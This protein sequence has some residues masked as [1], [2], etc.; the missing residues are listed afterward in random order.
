MKEIIFR[1]NLD[2]LDNHDEN[3]KVQAL[4]KLQYDRMKRCIKLGKEMEIQI[5]ASDNLG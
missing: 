3:W 2:S 4:R 5:L 1:E